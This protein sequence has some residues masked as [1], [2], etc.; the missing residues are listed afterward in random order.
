MVL[1]SC[2]ET[3]DAGSVAIAPPLKP[4]FFPL[5]VLDSNLLMA[6]TARCPRDFEERGV[7]GVLGTSLSSMLPLVRV[8]VRFGVTHWP[9]PKDIELDRASTRPRPLMAGMTGFLEFVSE[10]RGLKSCDGE[11]RHASQTRSKQ[12]PARTSK[13]QGQLSHL[14]VRSYY[15]II[16]LYLSNV[17]A[18]G[19]RAHACT[20]CCSSRMIALTFTP[21]AERRG[22]EGQ[23]MISS[24][25]F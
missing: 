25:C 20:L 21:T 22:G 4:D 13:N 8:R 1:E 5:I 6:F 17:S 19:L 18:P 11:G 2:A 14:V 16:L 9:R 15:R 3:G 10:L 24:S 12:E 7:L 23:H